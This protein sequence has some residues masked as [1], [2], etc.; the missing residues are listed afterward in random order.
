MLLQPEYKR[1]NGDGMV[2]EWC[3]EVVDDSEIGTWIKIATAKKAQVKYNGDKYYKIVT[4]TAKQQ[5]AIK[6]ELQILKG[7]LLGYNK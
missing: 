6:R 5:A 1:D 2:W 3:D 7:L 4:V